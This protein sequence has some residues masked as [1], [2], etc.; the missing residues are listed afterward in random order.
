MADM[1]NCMTRRKQWDT[2]SCKSCKK[3][4]SD[5]FLFEKKEKEKKAVGHRKYCL[6]GKA[7]LQVGKWGWRDVYYIACGGMGRTSLK[8]VLKRVMERSE[9]AALT[10]HGIETKIF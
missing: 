3:K 9:S 8:S 7:L 5:L 4:K 6:L 1:F 2:I 10:H